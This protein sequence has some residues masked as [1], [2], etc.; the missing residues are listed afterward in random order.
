M[1]LYDNV[2]GCG[3]RTVVE[4]CRRRSAT[5]WYGLLMTIYSG[6]LLHRTYGEHHA[7]IVWQT[8]HIPCIVCTSVHTLSDKQHISHALFVLPCTHCLTNNTYPTH[9]LNYLQSAQLKLPSPFAAWPFWTCHKKSHNMKAVVILNHSW[10]PF[11]PLTSYYGKQRTFV[12][13]CAD[14]WS[15]FLRKKLPLDHPCKWYDHDHQWADLV[16]AWLP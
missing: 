14:F 13:L 1:P 2:E 8:T 9:C 11:L 5:W 4:Q 16:M 3:I 12:G 10:S 15:I 6:T 7:H